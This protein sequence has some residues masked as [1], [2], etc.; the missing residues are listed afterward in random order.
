MASY[1]ASIAAYYIT[2]KELAKP[3][4]ERDLSVDWLRGRKVELLCSVLA[5]TS[6]FVIGLL[7]ALPVI[8]YWATVYWLIK[9]RRVV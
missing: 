1:L 3:I 8:L 5:W 2:K 9:T 6:F 7:A 4:G